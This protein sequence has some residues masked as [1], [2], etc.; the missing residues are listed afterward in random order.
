MENILLLSWGFTIFAFDRTGTR[1]LSPFCW[2]KDKIPEKFAQRNL[3]T[4]SFSSLV[5]LLMPCSLSARHASRFERL[6][7]KRW[8]KKVFST[9]RTQNVCF[10]GWMSSSV[11]F[12]VSATTS[13]ARKRKKEKRRKNERE[14]EV[15]LWSFPTSTARR[16]YV[17]V[18]LVFFCKICSKMFKIYFNRMLS[19][20]CCDVFWQKFFQVEI[21]Q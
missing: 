8:N 14:I 17:N 19:F 13:I 9:F 1:K 12:W 15:C 7:V 18:S 10:I 11:C 21:L 6:T 4:F 16:L 5:Y 3:F 2:K 20:R